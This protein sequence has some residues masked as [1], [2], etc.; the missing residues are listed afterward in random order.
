MLGL[1]DIF[2]GVA[3]DGYNVGKFICFQRANFRRQTKQI[4]VRGSSCF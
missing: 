1:A 4:R 3:G 2:D